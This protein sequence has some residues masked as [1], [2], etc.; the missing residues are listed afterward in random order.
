MKQMVKRIAS[1]ILVVTLCLT[2]GNFA[3]AVEE[4]QED[5]LAAVLQSKTTSELID[6]IP[7]ARTQ[8]EADAVFAEL[9]KR[10]RAGEA[11][12]GMIDNYVQVVSSSFNSSEATV[13]YR[14]VGILPSLASLSV[15]YEYPAAVH[16][17]GSFVNVERTTG[18]YTKTF[19]GPFL[20][21]QVRTKFR[22]IARNYTENKV[23]RTYT[24][25]GSGSSG[26]VIT[27]GDVAVGNVAMTIAGVLI[28]LMFGGAESIINLGISIAFDLTLN[29]YAAGQY[30]RTTTSVSGSQ[31]TVTIR[32]YA[33]LEAYQ[34]GSAPLSTRSSSATIPSF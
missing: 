34:A 25:V 13:T 10:Q 29:G 6:C 17:S 9:M 18:T 15:G 4:V 21:C 16:T 2:T 5:L 22:F 14:V 8:A 26:R 3:L 19:N 20:R 28:S 30:L 23:I 27:A 11:A 33:S 7:Q 32:Q 31:I 12:T 24:N 1:W